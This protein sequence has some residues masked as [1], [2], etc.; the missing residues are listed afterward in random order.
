MILKRLKA[1]YKLLIVAVFGLFPLTASAQ[2]AYILEVFQLEVVYG[3]EKLYPEN[4]LRTTLVEGEEQVL[5]VF[6]QDGFLYEVEFEATQNQT[7]VKLRR[8]GKLKVDDYRTVKGKNFKDVQFISKESDWVLKGKS[9]ELLVYDKEDIR[10][11]FI[12]FHYKL[13]PK[14]K[15]GFR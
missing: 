12:S 1:M 3:E 7:K 2:N 15:L 5:E 10:S 11:F 4:T 6:D 13:K 8:K 14:K 9:S